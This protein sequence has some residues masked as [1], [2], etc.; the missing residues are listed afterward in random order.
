MAAVIITKNEEAVI[1]RCLESV[2]WADEIILVD[3]G[4]VDR[5]VDIARALRART[6]ATP[7]WPGPGPQR[8]R[9][10]DESTY[11][12]LLLVDSDAYLRPDAPAALRAA[13]TQAGQVAPT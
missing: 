11:P 1:R 7:D 5:T 3:S 12:Y 9:A 6:V 10:I 4:S 8:N 2:Q 13:M